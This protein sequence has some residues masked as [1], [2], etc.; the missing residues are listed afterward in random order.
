MRRGI[1]S[2]AHQGISLLR[3]RTNGASMMSR[4]KRKN[5]DVSSAWATQIKGNGNGAMQTRKKKRWGEGKRQQTSREFTTSILQ[6]IA[7]ER[8]PNVPYAT[9]QAR[10]QTKSMSS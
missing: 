1:S 6:I 10:S 2:E 8:K 5:D 9:E 3:R 7:G 4:C